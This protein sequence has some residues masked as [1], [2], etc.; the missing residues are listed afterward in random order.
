MSARR[1]DGRRQGLEYG[2]LGTAS[3][4]PCVSTPQLEDPRF[5]RSATKSMQAMF[6][7]CFR[8]R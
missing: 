8:P 1:A 3:P 6:G 7:L 4:P 5:D 2:A